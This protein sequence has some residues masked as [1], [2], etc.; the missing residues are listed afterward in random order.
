MAQTDKV[1]RKTMA[2]ALT[3]YQ[4]IGKAEAGTRAAKGAAAKPG[5]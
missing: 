3:F 1:L 2:A 5:G 4:R